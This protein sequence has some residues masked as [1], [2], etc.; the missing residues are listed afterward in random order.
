MYHRLCA[1]CLYYKLSSIEDVMTPE[2]KAKVRQIFVDGIVLVDTE[3]LGDKR[4]A[5]LIAIIEQLCNKPPIDTMNCKEQIALNLANTFAKQKN[6]KSYTGKWTAEKENEIKA[7]FKKLLEQDQLAS[8]ISTVDSLLAISSDFEALE[9][10]FKQL[11]EKSSKFSSFMEFIDLIRSSFGISQSFVS[12]AKTFES[13]KALNVNALS[14]LGNAHAQ[15]EHIRAKSNH[16][17]DTLSK[18]ANP[19]S[20]FNQTKEDLTNAT[21]HI[22]N[23]NN[24]LS[25]VQ[26]TGGQALMHIQQS[27]QSLHHGA[28]NISHAAQIA[29]NLAQIASTIKEASTITAIVASTI[30]LV[31]I[32]I[33]LIAEKRKPTKEEVGKIILSAAILAMSIATLVVIAT[34]AAT[35]AGI[36]ALSLALAASVIGIGKT[37]LD[38]RDIKKKLDKA[39][40][41]TKK[42]ESEFI[43][44]K[45]EQVLSK[46]ELVEIEMRL[47]EEKN[48]S[49]PDLKR[50][51]T[52]SKNLMDK[53]REIANRQ[54]LIA[55]VHKKYQTST[56]K[57]NA[58]EEQHNNTKEKALKLGLACA[59]TVGVILLLASVLFPPAGAA[60]AIAGFAVLGTVAAV[61]IGN[62]GF[63]GIK[64][65]YSSIKSRFF[66]SKKSSGALS[67][68]EQLENQKD[69][70]LENENKVSL[71]A[72]STKELMESLYGAHA[73]S[74]LN[75]MITHEKRDAQFDAKYQKLKSRYNTIMHSPSKLL[76]F[77][78]HLEKSTSPKNHDEIQKALEK[79]F[80]SNEQ[81]GKSL[82]KA[83]TEIKQD[84]SSINNMVYE[85][86][87]TDDKSQMVK[88]V[89]SLSQ[90]SFAIE[91]QE[92]EP[93]HENANDNSYEQ[94]LNN[95]L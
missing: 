92:K 74:A 7:L 93:R 44:L 63:K 40:L 46:D 94:S 56:A 2:T 18:A 42:I 81:Y 57:K 34:V 31:S 14:T 39:V 21:A 48:K 88:T 43:A 66:P 35:T 67:N 24:H 36:V 80:S 3:E 69:I 87:F 41:E 84:P 25:Q 32:P 17:F 26:N 6:L 11:E 89:E 59:A 4:F 70:S 55:D 64:A 38:M 1:N 49:N 33:Q 75:E 60:L 79:L 51:D 76:G 86:F 83:I 30:G 9:T 61:S 16:Y 78:Y 91:P 77:L 95:K 29:Q 71:R 10:E 23:A 28:I 15:L 5:N 58:F 22:H 53:K 90:T 8:K 20:L 52:L 82:K 85:H 54:S 62:L 12:I 50:L 68:Q 37:L 27:S 72:Q 47:I 65:L 13:N 73:K 19:G 45:D